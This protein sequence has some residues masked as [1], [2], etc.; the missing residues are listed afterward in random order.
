MGQMT[1]PAGKYITNLISFNLH[2]Q[3]CDSTGLLLGSLLI[4][5]LE[6]EGFMYVFNSQ[7]YVGA[8]K[9]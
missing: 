3:E 4:L 5:W 6:K 1:V 8:A 2:S 7:N 9:P